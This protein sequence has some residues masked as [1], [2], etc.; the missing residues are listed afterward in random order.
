MLNTFWLHITLLI[1]IWSSLISEQRQLAE[2]E[3]HSQDGKPSARCSQSYQ[4]SAHQKG[5]DKKNNAMANAA[6]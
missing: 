6:R 1:W 3:G 2:A 5:K 4:V